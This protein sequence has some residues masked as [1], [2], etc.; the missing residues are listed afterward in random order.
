LLGFANTLAI[1]GQSKNIHVNTIA[2]MAGSR[3]TA[4]ILPQDILDALKPE[5]V[6]PLV[7]YLC[8][9]SCTENGGLFELGAGYYAKL[10]WERTKGAYLPIEKGIKPEDVQAKWATI[11]NWEGATHPTVVSDTSSAVMSAVQNKSKL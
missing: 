4:T 11:T 9:E 7:L 1:E 6:A 3:M 8:H 5:Y 2:P 10:R